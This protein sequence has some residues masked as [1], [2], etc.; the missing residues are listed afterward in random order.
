M[1]KKHS[2]RNEMAQA[3]HSFNVAFTETGKI[4][5]PDDGLRRFLIETREQI[6]T[7]KR[8]F[9]EELFSDIFALYETGTLAAEAVQGSTE[10]LE[11]DP[12]MSTLAVSSTVAAVYLLHSINAQR[13][14]KEHEYR[15]AL[16]MFVE[17]ENDTQNESNGHTKEERRFVAEENLR[18]KMQ[19]SGLQFVNLP[20]EQIR[21]PKSE[22]RE[23]AR[24][25]GIGEPI[26]F[27]TVKRVGDF[28]RKPMLEKV[29]VTGQALSYVMYQGERAAGFMG[30]VAT[31]YIKNPF[32]MH[33][34]AQ[35]TAMGF[36]E[37]AKLNADLAEQKNGDDADLEEP[38][39]KRPPITLEQLHSVNLRSIEKIGQ[40]WSREDK[41][42]MIT[43]M[44]D[45]EDHEK[46]AVRAKRSLHVQ[47]AFIGLQLAL[48][49]VKLMSE[50]HRH[51][52]GLNVYSFFAPLGPLKGFADELKSNRAKANSKLAEK[53]EHLGE[54]IGLDADSKTSEELRADN[55]DHDHD[56]DN[57]D[58]DDPDAGSLDRTLEP[59]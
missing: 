45:Q 19:H 1:E 17:F 42:K 20:D 58:Y 21:F 7:D 53:V 35:S 6:E 54:I 15:K 26:S 2:L 43:I 33:K 28:M 3:D 11:D 39:D 32:R 59:L 30:T 44:R 27:D 55:D 24:K 49:P 57:D 47:A 25:K 36:S 31:E 56:N 13:G 48:I 16:K 18:H 4:L 37:A 8:H 40:A 9:T 41:D 50:E 46:A 23:I 51:T 29:T 14:A 10:T 52:V 5:D 22:F 34:I 12:F 38:E